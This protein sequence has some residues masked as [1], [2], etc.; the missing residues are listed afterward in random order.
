MFPNPSVLY[1]IF[2]ASTVNPHRYVT[3]SGHTRSL[4]INLPQPRVQACFSPNPRGLCPCTIVP[5]PPWACRPSGSATARHGYSNCSTHG[6][7]APCCV[8]RACTERSC[9]L[10]WRT[11]NTSY[12]RQR[13]LCS[14]GKKSRKVPQWRNTISVTPCSRRKCSRPAA[15]M[16]AC[17]TE[18]FPDRAGDCEP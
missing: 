8:T 9:L 12:P 16:F 4:P 2:S 5:C 13:S 6:E 1:S 17:P 14:S 3:C 10:T 18:R 7:N 15:C 11:T